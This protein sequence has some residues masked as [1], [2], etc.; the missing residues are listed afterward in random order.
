[1][2]LRGVGLSRE[3]HQFTSPTSPSAVRCVR[4]IA[5]CDGPDTS[6]GVS[7]FAASFLTAKINEK[8]PTCVGHAARGR[9]PAGLIFPQH[10]CSIARRALCRRNKHRRMN[11]RPARPPARHS[12][13]VRI[14]IT[15]FRVGVCADFI[16]R[17]SQLVIC[18]GL[19]PNFI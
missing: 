16:L 1:M 8:R 4:T 9:W 12:A 2:C 14:R 11:L 18:S 3:A 5:Q 10:R 7:S 19:G 17:S 13:P 15:R 6:G